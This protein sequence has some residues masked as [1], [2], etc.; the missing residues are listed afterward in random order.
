LPVNARVHSEVVVVAKRERPFV[1][2]GK[3]TVVRG[4]TV[5]LYREEIEEVYRK[6]T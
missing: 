6:R 1:R 2:A 4:Q 5:E 3:G